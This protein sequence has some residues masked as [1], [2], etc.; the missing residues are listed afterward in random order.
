MCGFGRPQER[1]EA[2]IHE[3]RHYPAP[4]R[5]LTLPSREEFIQKLKQHAK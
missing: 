1:I 4:E 5:I 2:S 3:K